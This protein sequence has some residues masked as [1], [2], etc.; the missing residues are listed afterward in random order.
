MGHH[1]MGDG[2]D[3]NPRIIAEK[4]VDPSALVMGSTAENLHDR[5]PHLTKERADAFAVASQDKYAKA[6]RERQDRSPTWCRWPPAASRR[7][8][9]SRRADEPPRPGTT[10]ERPRHPEDPVPPARPGHGRQRRGP[11]RRRH[12]LPARRR[13]GRRASSGCRCGCAWCRSPSSA[14]SRR[15]WVSGPIPATEKALAKAGLAI[16]DIGLFE[17]NEAFA[18][19]VLAF[20]DHFGIADDDAA[21]QRVRRRDRGRPP[22]GVVR[23]AADDPAGPP[24]RGPPG[25]PL[26][27]HRH[28]RRHRH[29]RLGDLGEPALGRATRPTAPSGRTR[30]EQCSTSRTRSSPRLPCATST[31]PTGRGTRGAHH[32]RQRLR[33]HQADD[34]RPD[35]PAEHRRRHRR[36]ARPRRRRG[37]RRHRQAVHLRRRRR[38]QGDAGRRHRRHRRKAYFALGHDT[39]RK[40]RDAKVPTFAFVNGAVLGGGLELALHCHYRTLSAGVPAIAFP[41]VFLGLVPGWGGTPAAAEPRRC[42]QGRHGHRRERA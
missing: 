6:Y 13:G 41:E 4:L 15:S 36:G 21:G 39:F 30:R 2:V 18:V 37:G 14:S 1:P 33:P 27:P 31:C 17:L 5:F 26:R 12:G 9:A 11:Q 3:P 38:P 32:A 22:A 10:I 16:D 29:G 25:G 8:G 7:A 35:E 28:V 20:L 42:R 40:L 34:A 23:R 19:Q 24:V